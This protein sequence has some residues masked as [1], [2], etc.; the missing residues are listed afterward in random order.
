MRIVF[1]MAM[2]LAAATTLLVTPAEAQVTTKMDS[3]TH[4]RHHPDARRDSAFAA[5][6]ARGKTAMGVDQYTSTHVFEDSPVGGRI[7]L[8]RDG[9]DAE[10]IR[11][12]RA[13]LEEIA[14]AFREGDFH[15]PMF[16]HDRAVPG[17]LVM[18]ERKG[19]ITYSVR[20]LPRGGELRMTTQDP[21]AIAAIHAFLQ[22]QREDHRAGGQKH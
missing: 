4:A 20:D 15:T 9:D 8:Q 22:F 17:T 13:H 18:A 7:E 11:V 16:V 10:G 6:Q 12:I 3:A 1:R 19:S 5:L 2:L 21:A 14:E